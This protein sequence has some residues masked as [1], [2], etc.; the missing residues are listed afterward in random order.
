[1]RFIFLLVLCILL[2]S[3][4][5][6]SLDWEAICFSLYRFQYELFS[7]W[8]AVIFAFTSRLTLLGRFLVWSDRKWCS[9]GI[10]GMRVLIFWN[11]VIFNVFLLYLCCFLGWIWF[12]WVEV[13]SFW[14]WIFYLTLLGWQIN[15]S[16]CK[17]LAILVSERSNIFY[18]SWELGFSLLLFSILIFCISTIIV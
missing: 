17:W 4:R 9:S 18:F 11:W 10:W 2:V 5:S 16:F 15:T 13:K 7:L 6:G 8:L 14:I 3:L 1:M 12:W